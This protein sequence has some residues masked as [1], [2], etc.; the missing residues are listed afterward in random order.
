MDTL[1]AA[2]ESDLP[3]IADILVGHISKDGRK[4]FLESADRTNTRALDKHLA[5]E[6][7]RTT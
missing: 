5:R 6:E 2:L 1:L 4:A 7:G 3:K